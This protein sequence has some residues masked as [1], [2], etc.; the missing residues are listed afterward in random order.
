MNDVVTLE[1]W[2]PWP[3]LIPG[4]VLVVAVVASV[5]GTRHRHK[6]V[7]E[8]GYLGFLVAALAALAMVWVLS[9]IWDSRQRVEALTELGY[10]TPTFGGGMSFAAG[11]TGVVPF[12]AVHG[13]ERVRGVLRPLGGDQWEVSLVDEDEDD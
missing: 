8:L 9:A 6:R 3:L 1:P 13:E 7:R 12:Q 11:T 5:L 2:S 4:V 10:L